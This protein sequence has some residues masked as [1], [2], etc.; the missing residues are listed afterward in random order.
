MLP[1]KFAASFAAVIFAS[2]TFAVVTALEAIAPASTALSAS[3]DEPM[4]FAAI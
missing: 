3:S 1:G 4:A 2:N